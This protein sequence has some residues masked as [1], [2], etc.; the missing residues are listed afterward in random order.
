V[1]REAEHGKLPYLGLLTYYL[2]RHI[3]SIWPVL[4]FAHT[5]LRA[6]ESPGCGLLRPGGCAGLS[7][8]DCVCETPARPR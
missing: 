6:I 7:W 5:E 4:V 3:A 8:L 2:G 1:R